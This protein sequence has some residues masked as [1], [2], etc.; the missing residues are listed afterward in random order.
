MVALGVVGQS[1]LDFDRDSAVLAF[2]GRINR[3]EE[4]AGIA[5]IGGAQFF[6]RLIDRGRSQTAYLIG[7]SRPNASGPLRRCWG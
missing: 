4:V 2:G 7:N 3:G 6:D 1:W 5:H